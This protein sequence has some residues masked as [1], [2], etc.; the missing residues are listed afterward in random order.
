MQNERTCCIDKKRAISMYDIPI[1]KLQPSKKRFLDRTIWL[2]SPLI[3]YDSRYIE[4][5]SS[6]FLEKQYRQNYC[7]S[8]IINQN[9]EALDEKKNGTYCFTFM[10]KTVNFKI[11][12]S[13]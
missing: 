6:S 1:L 12:D 5:V 13:L 8:I 7:I 4:T 2:Q 9:L 10:K 11:G 3:A